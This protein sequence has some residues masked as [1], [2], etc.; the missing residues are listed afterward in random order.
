M[1]FLVLVG[2]S[3]LPLCACSEGASKADAQTVQQALTTRQLAEYVINNQLGPES[4]W[5]V[6]F[7]GWNVSFSDGTNFYAV[8]V[9]LDSSSVRITLIT[10]DST[11]HTL[12]RMMVDARMQNRVS[13]A[14]SSVIGDDQRSRDS[15]EY[16]LSGSRSV[17]SES[18]KV[19]NSRMA[20]ALEEIRKLATDLRVATH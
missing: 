11:K 4:R 14:K 7:G 12:I 15:E 16:L 20:A 10:R 18:G 1:R 6:V 9:P 13:W 3:A 17:N 19:W 5:K 2:L 8:F